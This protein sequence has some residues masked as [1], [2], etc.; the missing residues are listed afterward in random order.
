VEDSSLTITLSD[1][2]TV[3]GEIVRIENI[4]KDKVS[5]VSIIL[6]NAD[7]ITGNP[8]FKEFKIDSLIGVKNIPVSKIKTINSN[9]YNEDF[10]T[11][12]KW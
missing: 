10:F 8:D 6:R 9:H 5:F 2:S 12:I 7:M 3:K 11:G 4:D 1:N